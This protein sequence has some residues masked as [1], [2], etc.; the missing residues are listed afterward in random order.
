MK[1]SIRAPSH[2]SASSRKL[3]RDILSEYQINDAVGLRILQVA[4]E[5]LDRAEN[6]R[7]EIERNGQQVKDRF[8][9]CKSHV[10]LP[11]ERDARGQFLAAVKQLNLDIEPLRDKPGRP[12]GG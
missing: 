10:L 12:T 3:W 4:C 6:C 11:A 5:A 2:L 1:S 7:R 9:Q 8:G